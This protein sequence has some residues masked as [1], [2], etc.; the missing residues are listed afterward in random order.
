MTRI[1]E[2]C[3]TSN[4]QRAGMIR[5]TLIGRKHYQDIIATGIHIEVKSLLDVS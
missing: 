2:P 3:A 1:C 4:R 5:E